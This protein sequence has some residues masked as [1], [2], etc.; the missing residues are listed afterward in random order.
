M[1]SHRR[2]PDR[3]FWNMSCRLLRLSPVI[4]RE[5][6]IEVIRELAQPHTRVVGQPLAAG[7]YYGD[8]DR[9]SDD[10]CGGN[11]R[12]GLCFRWIHEDLVSYSPNRVKWRRMTA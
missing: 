12:P 9:A 11:D 7:W 5:K 3:T 6:P 4:D 10:Q 1:I 2:P 8:F